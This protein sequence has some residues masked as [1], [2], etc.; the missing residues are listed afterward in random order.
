MSLRDPELD[1]LRQQAVAVKFPL[2]AA[3]RGKLEMLL[4]KLEG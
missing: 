1:A 4:V 2:N 3:D